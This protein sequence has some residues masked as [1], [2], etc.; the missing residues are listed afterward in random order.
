MEP[1]RPLLHVGVVLLMS[2]SITPAQMTELRA[3]AARV[4]QPYGVSLSWLDGNED[5]TL[6]SRDDW[7]EP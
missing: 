4:W 7:S 6:A 5:C 3:E 2:G 1:L